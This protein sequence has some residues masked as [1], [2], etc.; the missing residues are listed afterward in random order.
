MHYIFPVGWQSA[1]LINF[2][3]FPLYT[4]WQKRKRQPSKFYCQLILFIQQSIYRQHYE[5]ILI[6]KHTSNLNMV[7]KMLQTRQGTDFNYLLCLYTTIWPLPVGN[8]TAITHLFTGHASLKI[9]KNIYCRFIPA[10]QTHTKRPK[11]IVIVLPTGTLT[12]VI[13][14]R[15]LIITATKISTLRNKR[16]QINAKIT[17]S[18]N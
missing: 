5:Y 7:N 15:K 6:L 3:P 13:Q 14:Q 17:R 10:T 16:I 9:F 1:N 8:S 18:I 2:W 4:L 12:T 11:K